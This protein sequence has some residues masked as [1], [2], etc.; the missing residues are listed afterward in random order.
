MT[1]LSE[2]T[3]AIVQYFLVATCFIMI[4]VRMAIS[5]RT[6]KRWSTEDGWM[7]V[8]LCFLVGVW[9]AGHSIHGGGTNNVAHPELLTAAQIRRREDGSKS[10]VVGRVSYAS[11]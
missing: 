11:A 3:V 10:T 4:S 5:W 1:A 7:L 6:N 2:T 8:A 9:Y